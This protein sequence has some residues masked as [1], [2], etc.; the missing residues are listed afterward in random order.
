MA[1]IVE[2]QEPHWG[3]GSGWVRELASH[4]PSDWLVNGGGEVVDRDPSEIAA[5]V[6]AGG[7]W[8]DYCGYPMYYRQ[9]CLGT[10]PC[11]NQW[12]GGN[13]FRRFL[14]G[15]GNLGFSH[16]FM[17]DGFAFPRALLVDEPTIPQWI[18]PCYAPDVPHESNVFAAFG[19]KPPGSAGWYFYAYGVGADGVSAGQY[20]QF[21]RQT[22][23]LPEPPDNPPGEGGVNVLL[24]L[25][26]GVMA[27][28]LLKGR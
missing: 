12:L 6:R 2:V 16:T 21:I 26:G 8:V 23:G 10:G 4:L 22:A 1:T 19:L 15:L 7:A 3:A 17:P 14:V 28:L 25:L 18:Y 11:G 27:Y 20:L 5:F 24:A 9:D 13:G